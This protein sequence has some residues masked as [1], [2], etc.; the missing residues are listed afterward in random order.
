[1]PGKACP[2]PECKGE[3]DRMTKRTAVLAVIVIAAI[4]VV[5]YYFDHSLDQKT[6]TKESKGF[7]NKNLGIF[8][9]NIQITPSSSKKIMD[10]APPEIVLEPNSGNTTDINIDLKGNEI[11]T[12][13]IEIHFKDTSGIETAMNTDLLDPISEAVIREN[14]L[15]IDIM[16]AGDKFPE[17]FRI[18]SLAHPENK[19]YEIIKIQAVFSDKFGNE[20]I[21]PKNGQIDDQ[22]RPS[23]FLKKSKL[24]ISNLPRF[25]YTLQRRFC[26]FGLVL[27]IFR[28]LHIHFHSFFSALY[29]DDGV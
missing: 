21:S 4:A 26:L 5:G 29:T 7:S 19:K 1:M 6:I 15:V 16:P 25:F 11:Y 2:Y 12:M 27:L 10:V 22:P 18:A 20:L 9:Q 3:E 17:K 23:S 14:M 13:S 8:P 28:R 24:F